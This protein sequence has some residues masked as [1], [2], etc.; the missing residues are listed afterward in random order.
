NSATAQENLLALYF[1]LDEKILGFYDLNYSFLD[2]F[3]SRYMENEQQYLTNKTQSYLRFFG[4][5]SLGEEMKMR[6]DKIKVGNFNFG[7]E[8]TF[9]NVD[10]HFFFGDI[11]TTRASSIGSGTTKDLLD[12]I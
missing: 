4:P 2:T 1:S 12:Y 6:C 5:N 3:I 9:A 7:F 11:Y 10:R 8:Q